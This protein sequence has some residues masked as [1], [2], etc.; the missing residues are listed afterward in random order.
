MSTC[1]KVERKPKA[2]EKT[3][4]GLVAVVLLG[5][6]GKPSGDFVTAVDSKNIPDI[7][8]TNVPIAIRTT[9]IAPANTKRAPVADSYIL[10]GMRKF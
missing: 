4:S 2:G 8:Q 5:Q 3:A 1:D 9:A 7:A 6:D 10:P